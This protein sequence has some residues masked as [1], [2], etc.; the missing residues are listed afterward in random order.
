[1]GKGDHK[2][3]RGKIYRGSYGNTRPHAAVSAVAGAQSTGTKSGKL[4]PLAAKPAVSRATTTKKPASTAAAKKP[5]VTA[6]K[7]KPAV[8]KTVD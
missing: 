1:M 4:K 6:V 5:A 7:K 3:R 8:K 2:T